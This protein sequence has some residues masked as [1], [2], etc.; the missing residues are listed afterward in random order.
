MMTTVEESA[1]AKRGA[2][3][4]FDFDFLREG[5]N[6]LNAPQRTAAMQ[7]PPSI[8]KSSRRPAALSEKSASCENNFEGIIGQ[9]AAIKALR[10]KIKVVA[11]TDAP[12][13]VLGET[14]TGKELIARAIHNLSSRGDRPFIKVN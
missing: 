1:D 11:P 7:G 9:S 6:V 3:A 5:A 12:T 13:L 8:Y 2:L 4:R 10:E 14:G